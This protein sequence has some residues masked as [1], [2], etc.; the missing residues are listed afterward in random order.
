MRWVD[1]TGGPFVAIEARLITTWRGA[2]GYPAPGTDY[3]RACEVADYLGV[4]PVGDG[5]ALVLGDEPMATAWWPDQRWG[6]G[7]IVRWMYAPDETAVVQHLT[8]L[9]EA[10]FVE[11]VT[12]R[13]RDVIRCSS[14]RH[15][16]VG[17]LPSGALRSLW[18]LEPIESIPMSP[19]RTTSS[20]LSCTVSGAK[21]SEAEAPSLVPSRNALKLTI[22]TWRDAFGY[23][24]TQCPMDGE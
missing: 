19:S 23:S 1:T 24:V 4:V 11:P 10:A 12:W 22:L 17:R 3:G 20:A 7:L 5:S 14:I 13:V 18:T 9:S 8:A 6:S 21:V 16:R 15:C 2:I